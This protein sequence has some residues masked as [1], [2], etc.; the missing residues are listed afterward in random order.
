M[1]AGW[2]SITRQTQQNPI[3]QVGLTF[4]DVGQ[5]PIDLL[6]FNQADSRFL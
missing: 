1:H 3:R 5:E 4:T 2:A 6:G